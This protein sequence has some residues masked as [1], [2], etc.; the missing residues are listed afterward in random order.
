MEC[1]HLRPHLKKHKITWQEYE[2]QYGQSVSSFN[3]SKKPEADRLIEAYTRENY[4]RWKEER[5]Q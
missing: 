3:V 4:R 1:L 5:G 2:A